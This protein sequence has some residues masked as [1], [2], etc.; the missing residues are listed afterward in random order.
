MPRKMVIAAVAAAGV[1]GSSSAAVAT[2]G[3]LGGSTFGDVR[4]NLSHV[5]EVD[6][7]L[8]EVLDNPRV[9]L[10]APSEFARA[11]EWLRPPTTS[12]PAPVR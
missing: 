12:A 3:S 7:R 9:N 10:P 6:Y 2:V 1:V 8:A 5:A 11:V 4:G